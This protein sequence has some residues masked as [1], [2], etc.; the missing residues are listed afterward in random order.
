MNTRIPSPLISFVPLLVL[1]ALLSVTIYTFGDGALSG[2]SQ[3]CLLVA[4]AVCA[5]IGMWRYGLPWKTFEHAIENNVKRVTEALFILLVIGALSGIWMIGGIVPTMIYYGLQIIH[6]TFFL[7]TTCVLCAV[8][9]LMTGSSWTTVATIG[10]AL[11]GIGQAQGFHE[12]WVAGAIISGS[13]FGDKMSPLSDTTVLASSTVGVR[14]F[15]H[16]RYLVFTTIPALFCALLVYLIAGFTLPAGD[17]TSIQT[18]AD[19]LQ[20]KFDISPWALIVPILTAVMIW[21]RLPSLITLFISTLLAAIFALLYQPE[22]LLELASNESGAL[23]LFKGTMQAIFGDTQLEMGSAELNDLVGTGGMAGMMDTIWLILCAMCFGGVMEA[24][25]FLAGISRLFLRFVRK[26]FSLVSS[27][28]ASGILFNV[29]TAD[30]YISII[31][32]GN[33]F[34]QTY[35]DQGHEARLL[36]RTTEDAVTVTSPL[37]PW[38]TCGMT[39]ATVMGVATWT[40]LPYAVFNYLCPLFSMIIAATGFRI[41]KK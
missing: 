1:V 19:A 22:V 18:Y 35:H 28:V 11:I 41:F 9:S 2:G 33:M 29:V 32:T 15:T 38:N 7:L 30:Q 14:L 21:K 26:T 24:G 5:T 10:V 16:I 37:I 36:S 34:K 3:I 23:A 40:Y 27:T 4:S 8:V 39:Q 20:A 12:G 17:A 13:Y 6:P 25:G 31:L